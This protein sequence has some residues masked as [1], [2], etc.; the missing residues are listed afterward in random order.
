MPPTQVDIA[1][2]VALAD[3]LT[4]PSFA[5]YLDVIVHEGMRPGEVDALRWDRIDFQAG[6]ILVDQQWNAKVREFTLPKHQVVRTIALTEPARKRLLAVAAR[7]GVRVPD[8]ARHPLPPSARS[9]ALEPRPL[10]R[11]ALPGEVGS[12]TLLTALAGC[13]LRLTKSGIEAPCVVRERA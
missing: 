13:A 12:R 9:H 2:F 6:T 8:A 1:R 7:V 11:R 3:E 10:H 5:A 4:P